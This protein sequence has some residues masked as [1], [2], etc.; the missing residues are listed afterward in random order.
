MPTVLIGTE[1][2][3]CDDIQRRREEYAVSYFVLRDSQFR[4]AA[5]I[6]SRLVNT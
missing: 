5:P 1:H 2:Q 3:I 4:A 6:V